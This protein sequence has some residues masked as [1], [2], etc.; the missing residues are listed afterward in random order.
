[1][2]SFRNVI[3]V[4]ALI[5]AREN[6]RNKIIIVEVLE[7]TKGLKMVIEEEEASIKGMLR[8]IGYLTKLKEFIPRQN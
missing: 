4:N 2:D 8:E 6:L 7:Q 3:G 1:M 5:D